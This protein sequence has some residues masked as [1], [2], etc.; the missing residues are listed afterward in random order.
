MA[1]CTL[2]QASRRTLTFCTEAMQRLAWE[3][4]ADS[5]MKLTVDYAPCRS[6]QRCVGGLR[7]KL[8]NLAQNAGHA[9]ALV[10]R[11]ERPQRLEHESAIPW[12]L[13]ALPARCVAARR[14]A[15][16]RVDQAYLV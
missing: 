6:C 5:N 13:P 10:F 8:T 4:R 15:S 3:S 9:H 11:A 16:R 12:P 7:E 14:L 2:E 1:L